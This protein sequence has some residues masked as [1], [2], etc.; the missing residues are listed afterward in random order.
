MRTLA[1]RYPE[2]SQSMQADLVQFWRAWRGPQAFV[3]QA[4]GILQGVMLLLLLAVC[5]NTANLVLAR[6]SAR[7][8][9][10]GVRLAIG[11]GWWRIARLLLVENL[12]LGLIASALGA[13]VAVWGTNAL[14][15]VPLLTT[16]FPVRF[17][18]RHRSGGSCLR[19]GARHRLRDRL[20]RRTRLADGAHRSASG[21]PVGRRTGVARL[22]AAMADGD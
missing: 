14:R 7:Q 19:R 20:R 3:L 16:Q 18:T 12:V 8:R 9:E 15:A 2:S 4:L 6:A 13:L 17:Q 11:A 22:D 1:A 5:G 21:P 10:I